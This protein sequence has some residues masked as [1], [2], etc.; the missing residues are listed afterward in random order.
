M[1]L[2]QFDDKTFDFIRRLLSDDEV[3]RIAYK[4]ILLNSN[5]D[6]ELIKAYESFNRKKAIKKKVIRK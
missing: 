1:R 5:E 2:I 4:R 6:E 3:Q